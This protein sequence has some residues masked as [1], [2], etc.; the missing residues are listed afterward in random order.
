MTQRLA[1]AFR[2]TEQGMVGPFLSGDTAGAA[3]FYLLMVAGWWRQRFDFAGETPRL[4]ACLQSVADGPSAR[5]AYAAQESIPPDFLGAE[6][7]PIE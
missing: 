6:R 4:A 7:R 5:G 1:S 3:E 2:A